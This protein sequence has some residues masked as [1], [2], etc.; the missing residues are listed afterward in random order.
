MLKVED[1]ENDDIN[2]TTK[3][4][5]VEFRN[6]NNGDDINDDY[7]GDGDSMQ[8]FF[9]GNK[10]QLV[11]PENTAIYE[12]LPLLTSN[13]KNSPLPDLITLRPKNLNFLPAKEKKASP[14]INKIL[15][16]NRNAKQLPKLP[17]SFVN[18][19]TKKKSECMLGTQKLAGE[20]RKKTPNL[21]QRHSK[22]SEILSSPMPYY[23]KPQQLLQMNPCYSFNSYLNSSRLNTNHLLQIY[24]NAQPEQIVLEIGK[25]ANVNSINLPHV[26][27]DKHHESNSGES[28]SQ[29][30]PAAKLNN[31]QIY[32]VKLPPIRNSIVSNRESNFREKHNQIF[33]L[34]EG[35]HDEVNKILKK[36]PSISLRRQFNLTKIKSIN[37]TNSN[38]K[39]TNVGSNL[40]VSNTTLEHYIME[41]IQAGD[42]ELKPY[43]D[44]NYGNQIKS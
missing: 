25:Q 42:I 3:K 15:A 34:S 7:Y 38:N 40:F 19:N 8:R 24:Q 26:V 9:Y 33:N 6:F 31:S 2:V 20:T 4:Y 18:L 23:L 35:I 10:Y 29:R 44:I 27:F 1:K 22:S 36:Y 32:S 16:S 43:D 21:D 13:V 5:I 30:K 11:T 41:S 37:N 28:K 12:N 17:N 14:P 39:N